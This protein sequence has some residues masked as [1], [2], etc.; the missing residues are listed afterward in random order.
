MRPDPK[1]GLGF[2]AAGHYAGAVSCEDAKALVDRREER[3]ERRARHWTRE[4]IGR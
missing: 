1:A 4:P 3:E 2:G